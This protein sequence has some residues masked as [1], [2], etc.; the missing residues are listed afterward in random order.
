MS[1]VPNGIDTSHFSPLPPR[2][3]TPF[4]A[5]ILCRLTAW[6]RVEWA[7]R[8]SAVANVNLVVVGDGEEQG[9]LV[10]L[11]RKERAPVRFVG[12]QKDTRPFFA[13][14]DVTINASKADPMP[15]SVLESLSMER[16][17]IA[18]ED[19][20]IPEVVEHDE[21]GWLLQHQG[22]EPLAQ[23][24]LRAKAERSRLPAMGVAGRHFVLSKATTTRMCGGYAAEYE[25]LGRLP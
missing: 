10:G 24:L 14:C 8:A 2:P 5:A 3:E 1:V 15:I 6:K 18:F 7:V 22:V 9:R 20:G 17:V 4:S 12:Y 23:A 21:T 19:G 16:P 11:A 25:R 13:A